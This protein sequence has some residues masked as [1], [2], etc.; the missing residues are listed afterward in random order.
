MQDQAS[1]ALVT[2]VASAIA[3]GI[4]AMPTVDNYDDQLLPCSLVNNLA[5]NTHEQCKFVIDNECLEDE[6]TVDY[7][8]M[9]F[10]RID[11]E[12]RLLAIALVILLVIVL[13][14]NLSAVADEFLCPSLLTVAKNL[15]MSDSLAVSS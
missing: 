5:K 4:S 11:Y 3:R 2:T 6:A 10:C 8:Y 7:V 15:R 12:L 1:D 9:V 14:L 13:F